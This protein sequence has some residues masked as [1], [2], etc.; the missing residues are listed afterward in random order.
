[1]DCLLKK[2]IEFHK[3]I[4]YRKT[5]KLDINFQDYKRQRGYL[6]YVSDPSRISARKGYMAQCYSICVVYM[7][8]Q[9]L[10]PSLRGPT[11]KMAAD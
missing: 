11:W 1:M 4:V 8:Y 3:F 5:V 6:I 10:S 9:V 7:I 2:S